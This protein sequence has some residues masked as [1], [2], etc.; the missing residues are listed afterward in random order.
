[1][2]LR[3]REEDVRMS[4]AATGTPRVFDG[5]VS[6]VTTFLERVIQLNAPLRL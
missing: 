5:E 4:A 2:R 3:W 1:M 6:H